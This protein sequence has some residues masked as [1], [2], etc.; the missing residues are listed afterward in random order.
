MGEHD[1][2]DVTISRD[3]IPNAILRLSHNL[4]VRNFD[5]SGM[6][7]GTDVV[8]ESIDVFERALPSG[9]GDNHWEQEEEEENAGLAR[10]VKN[11]SLSMFR[12]KLVEHFHI[13]WS[14][15]KIVWPSAKPK[16]D[17]NQDTL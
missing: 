13:M 4:T 5:S 3:S 14:R 10:V 6:G 9:M 17:K 15:N 7:P 16:I 8:D 1:F 11:I 12:H 2:D